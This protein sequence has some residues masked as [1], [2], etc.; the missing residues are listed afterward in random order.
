M[1]VA[2]IKALLDQA[3][4]ATV[5]AIIGIP[6]AEY[7]AYRYRACLS[8]AAQIS[9]LQLRGRISFVFAG[10][11]VPNIAMSRIAIWNRGKA[12]I[13]G[14]DIASR[15]RLRIATPEGGRILEATV[16]A[17]TQA[18]NEFALV[19]IATKCGVCS[20]IMTLATAR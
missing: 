4:R 3:W 5:I 13:P 20:T 17:T 9:T 1:I 2:K 6:V 14:Q 16:L 10:N 15:D 18:V 7:V 19:A 8:L 12:V 11:V